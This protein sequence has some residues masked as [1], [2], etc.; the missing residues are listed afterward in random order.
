MPTVSMLSA[1][2][3][4]AALPVPAPVVPLIWLLGKVQSGK[5]SIIRA[6]TGCS[7]VEIGA[8]FKPCT[9]TARVF[10]Y[11]HNVPLVHFMDTRGLGEVFYDPTADI[12][13]AEGQANILLVVM[14]ALDHQQQAVLDVVKIVRARHPQWPLV[15]AQTAL[16][17]GYARSVK[18]VLPY[19]FDSGDP[20][21][22]AAAGVPADLVRSVVAQRHLFDEVRNCRNIAFV[23]LDFT[24]PGAG[25]EPSTYGLP[26]LITAVQAA[27]PVSV[28]ASLREA[29]HAANAK[30]AAGIHAKIVAHATT[31]AAA[32]VVPLIGVIAVPGIQ[33]NMLRG[34]AA[35]FGTPWDRYSAT[36]FAACLGTGAVIRLVSTFGIRELVK[37]I[38]VY[39]Q[40][41]GTAAAAA[42]SFATTFAVGKAAVL[43]LSQRRLGEVDAPAVVQIYRES[44]KSAFNLAPRQQPRGTKSDLSI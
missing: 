4:D 36:Q 30:I 12:A 40:T 6:V 9:T 34:V 7:D 11:P 14:N 25:H 29:A 18:H 23:A 26:A 13:L 20:V 37:L 15:V 2:K 27:A 42:S 44:L 32:D 17:A 38:P 31:A 3:T 43:F 21:R 39:G 28:A 1:H 16:H 5:S 10:Q 35:A 33:V 22:W 41:A 19:P 8:G 24:R